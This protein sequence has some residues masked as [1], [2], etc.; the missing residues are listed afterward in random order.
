MTQ[1]DT[2]AQ[3]FPTESWAFVVRMVG[4]DA[5][6]ISNRGEVSLV[7]HITLIYLIGKL[8]KGQRP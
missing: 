8:L 4:H 7:D 2:E 5:Y 1:S 6:L 3:G